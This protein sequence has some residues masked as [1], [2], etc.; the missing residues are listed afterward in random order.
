MSGDLRATRPLRTGGKDY[1]LRNVSR[2]RR[3]RSKA[4][5]V[6]VIVTTYNRLEELKRALAS[7]A[8]Q[9]L[10][11]FE[12][13][14]ADAGDDGTLWFLRNS[15]VSARLI[16]VPGNPGLSAL[17][18][19]GLAVARGEFVA[20]LESD[21]YW[22]PQY[23]EAMIGAFKSS[24]VKS[25]SCAWW[26]ENAHGEF[27]RFEWKRA[28]FPHPDIAE[29]R[30]YPFELN[31]FQKRFCAA[32]SSAEGQK[33]S[34]LNQRDVPPL[35]KSKHPGAMFYWGWHLSFTMFRRKVFDALGGFDPAL[36]WAGVDLDFHARITLAYGGRAYRRLDEQLGVWTWHPSSLQIS[37]LICNLWSGLPRDPSLLRR[38]P[39]FY[40]DMLLDEAYYLK[41]HAAKYEEIESKLQLK[42]PSVTTS[43]SI[44]PMKR[45]R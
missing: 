1:V 43:R 6:S 20:F 13:I 26:T 41:K 14:V 22:L 21:D 17:M 35:T 9:T 25:V 44:K 30:A 45:R 32:S 18:N 27:K 28:L 34:V 7:V 31:R 10:Q 19:A 5:A 36:K 8:G 42:N 4:P 39:Q 16:S 2:Y 23:L 33:A 24:E 12:I 15:G 38:H 3:R 11:D 29:M 37:A 40:R